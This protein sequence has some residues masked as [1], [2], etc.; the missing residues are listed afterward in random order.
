M[1]ESGVPRSEPHCCSIADEVVHFS[2][3]SHHEIFESAASS[4]ML[5]HLGGGTPQSAQPWQ[6]FRTVSPLFSALKSKYAPLKSPF[7][8]VLKHC[9]HNMFFFL[10][11]RFSQLDLS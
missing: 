3:T 1:T 11:A 6:A 10:V 8:N 7:S 2:M 4:G 5:G 9:T